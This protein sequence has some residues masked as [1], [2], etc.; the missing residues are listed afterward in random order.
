MERWNYEE[1]VV[2]ERS[3]VFTQ[4]GEDYGKLRSPPV[5]TAW[6]YSESSLISSTLGFSFPWQRERFIAIWKSFDIQVSHELVYKALRHSRYVY[7]YD[8]VCPMESQPV[9]KLSVRHANYHAQN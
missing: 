9:K 6:P 5:G 3:E 1:E 4:V 8:S 7:V 2:N